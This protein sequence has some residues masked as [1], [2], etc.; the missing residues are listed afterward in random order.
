MYFTGDLYETIAKAERFR[1]WEEKERKNSTVVIEKDPMEEM[2]FSEGIEQSSVE[3]FALK[4]PEARHFIRPEEVAFFRV[5]D[6]KIVASTINGEVLTNIQSSLVKIWDALEGK[7]PLE[8]SFF[9][10]REVLI[11]CQSVSKFFSENLAAPERSNYVYHVIM[12]TGDTLSIPK[13]KRITF[14]EK[15][16]NYTISIEK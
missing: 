4:S 6:N 13:G 16:N 12:E 7:G 11:N 8:N 15:M 2:T 9:Q 1:S 5:E 10:T 14:L 3:K